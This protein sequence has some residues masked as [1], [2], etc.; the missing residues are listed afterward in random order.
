[1]TDVRR[2]IYRAAIAVA[3]A[4]TGLFVG[5]GRRE[6]PTPQKTVEMGARFTSIPGT[7]PRHD[8]ERL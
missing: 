5:C 1:M 3:V 2:S 8:A 6:P 7:D 4:S